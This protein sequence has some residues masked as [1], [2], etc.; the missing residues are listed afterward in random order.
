MKS[1]DCN[2]EVTAAFSPAPCLK[3]MTKSRIAIRNTRHDCVAEAWNDN[4][5]V[6]T[7]VEVTHDNGSIEKTQTASEAW[8]IHKAV[9]KLVGIAGC[10]SLNRVRPVPSSNAQTEARRSRK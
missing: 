9:V 1:P 2:P 5:P 8:V 10:Y 4:H 7:P 3:F 6:G